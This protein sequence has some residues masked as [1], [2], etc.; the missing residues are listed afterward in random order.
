MSIDRP[1]LGDHKLL[2]KK[3]PRDVTTRD[4]TSAILGG[5][6][7]KA[8][9]ADYLK[10]AKDFVSS[11]PKKI[12]NA[13]GKIPETGPRPAAQSVGAQPGFF[14]SFKNKINSPANKARTYAG[15]AAVGTG[16]AGVLAYKGYKKIDKTIGSPAPT[17]DW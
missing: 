9:M 3:G 2:F 1:V 7:K 6:E 17:Q 15:M 10:P 5:F 8:A 16:A 4:A 12:S 13:F 11:I 14:S